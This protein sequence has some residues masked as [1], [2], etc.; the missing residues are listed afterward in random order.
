MNRIFLLIVFPLIF[1]NSIYA[2][3][4]H[5][6]VYLKNGNIIHGTIKDTSETFSLYDLNGNILVFSQSEIIK[7]KSVKHYIANFTSAGFIMGS[8]LNQ[9]PTVLSVLNETNF[10]FERYFGFGITSGV[11]LLNETTIP[12]ALNS[13]IFLPFRSGKVFINGLIG[14]SFP[15]DKPRYIDYEEVE[16][17]Y[18]GVITGISAGLIIPLKF[19]NGLFFEIGYRYNELEYKYNNWYYGEVK[20]TQYMNRLNMRFGLVLF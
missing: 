14:K 7:I 11:E 17:A 9:K 3:F 12:F 18:G 5:E 10:L 4:D 13:K 16:A 6:I 1:S 8:A 15:A 2:Q 20:R 19:N